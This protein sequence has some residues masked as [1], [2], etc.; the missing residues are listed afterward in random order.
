M[1]AEMERR[2]PAWSQQRTGKIPEELIFKASVPLRPEP[3]SLGAFLGK[4]QDAC[5][6]V[7]AWVNLSEIFFK[8]SSMLLSS[9][10]FVCCEVT[11]SPHDVKVTWLLRQSNQ[12][13]VT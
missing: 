5:V 12:V 2:D 6:K 9:S 4:L 8:T 10:V 7:H 3:T 11:S 1:A 13:W